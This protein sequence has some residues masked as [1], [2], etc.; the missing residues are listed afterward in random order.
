MGGVTSKDMNLTELSQQI[1]GNN[2]KKGF[3]TKDKEVASILMLI[4]SE[5]SEA[6][7][8]DEKLNY[9]GNK[10]EIIRIDSS[11]KLERQAQIEAFEN[12]VKDTF[13]DKLANSIIKILDLAGYLEI[14][15]HS[16]L[17]EKLKY[18]HENNLLQEH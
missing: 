1:H 11:D 6:M 13:E 8:Q 12:H 18:N 5:L 14:D 2:V 17:V 16:H 15:I 7:E 10:R 9:Y 3:Y 4:V